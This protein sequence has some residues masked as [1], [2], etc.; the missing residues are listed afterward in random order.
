MTLDESQDEL[1]KLTLCQHL[2]E[3]TDDNW[4]TANQ[5]KLI[6]YNKAKDLDLNHKYKNQASQKGRYYFSLRLSDTSLTIWKDMIFYI[7]ISGLSIAYLVMASLTLRVNPT[8][9]LESSC[10]IQSLHTVVQPRCCYWESFVII[11]YQN[12]PNPRKIHTSGN[13]SISGVITKPIIQWRA[14][15][16]STKYA[17]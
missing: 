13:N 14:V 6:F 7:T 10:H 3:T 5:V 16:S 15:L 11:Y 12:V 2:L 4:V 8:F 1:K 9:I 17:G